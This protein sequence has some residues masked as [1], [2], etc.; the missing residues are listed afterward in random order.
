MK[1]EYRQVKER[2]EAEDRAH[3]LSDDRI[4]AMLN[5]E[6]MKIARRTVAK[7]RGELKIPGATARRD[8]V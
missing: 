1:M 8:M 4:A 3:P 2:V 7:Y 5:A 6:G